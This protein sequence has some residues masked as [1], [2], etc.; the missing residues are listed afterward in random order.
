MTQE[1]PAT[2]GWRAYPR[3]P[4]PAIETLDPRFDK[5]RLFSAAVERLHTGSRWAEGPVWV[6][7]GRYLLWS[8]IPNN[9]ILKWEEETGQVSLY[10][11]P[12]DHANG[13]TRDRQGRLV[14]CEHGGRRVTRTEYDGSI[15]VLMDKWQGK[16]LNS[17]NDVVVKSD[18]SIW[19]TDPPFG[20]HGDYEGHKAEPELGHAV[21]R[22]DGTTGQA[23]IVADDVLGPNGLC[24]SPDEKIL[25]IVESRG[26]PYRKILAYD[27]TA[28][29]TGIRNKRV[30][31]DAGP[32]GTPDGM[33]CDVDGNIWAGWGMGTPELDGV[34]VFAPDGTKIGRVALPERCANVCFGGPKR[35]RLFMAASQSVY[36]LYVNT[37]GVAGG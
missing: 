11:K 37:Q 30:F 18:G 27:V 13:H 33:R 3:Y 32:G 20:I 4:D 7:D 35:N 28:E 34:L 24:F 23:S 8:D 26:V 6:G 29:G 25:Y 1:N 16:R 22:I 14:T 36:A 21:Y 12:S 15:T 10:R 19:F 17:P 2:A 5:Y 31:V 9:R